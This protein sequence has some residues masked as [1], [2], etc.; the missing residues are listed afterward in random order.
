[1]SCGHWQLPSGLEQDEICN[2]GLVLSW[3]VVPIAWDRV[4]NLVQTCRSHGTSRLS[5]TAVKAPPGLGWDK[6]TVPRLPAEAVA[7]ETF[8]TLT[9][10]GLQYSGAN[11]SAKW[12]SR[13]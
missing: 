8:S 11:P 2:G 1:M 7:T 10:E 9:M 5:V 12:S 3:V 4:T 6:N 13:A